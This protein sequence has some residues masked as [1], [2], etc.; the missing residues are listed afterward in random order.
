M[1][2]VTMMK[3]TRDTESSLELT[4]KGN[5][6]AKVDTGLDF[7]D[8]MLL[9]LAETSRMD[10][11]FTSKISN[12]GFKPD[13]LSDAGILIG[14]ATLKLISE[15]EGLNRFQSSF[16]PVGQTLAFTTLDMFGRG[17]LFSDFDFKYEMIDDVTSQS[18]EEFFRSFAIN[19]KLTLH[20]KIMY[21]NNDKHKVTALM[22]SFGTC[23]RGAFR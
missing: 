19:S 5:G 11:N 12:K 10:I 2:D 9:I 21:G 1:A 4:L 22:S 6:A 20:M 17:E 7:F 18:I 14:S 16:V 15:L 3:K 8:H 23:L 13:V